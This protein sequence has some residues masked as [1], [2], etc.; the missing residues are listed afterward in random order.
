MK[1]Y[2]QAAKAIQEKQPDFKPKFAIITGSGLGD[3]VNHI[4]EAFSIPYQDIPHFPTPSVSGH[5]GQLVLGF[6]HGVPVACL[7][8]RVHY[9]EGH[10]NQVMT[11]MLRT[12]K[13][14]G[15]DSLLV[16][17][18]SGSMNENVT[19]GNLVLIYD[20]INMQGRNPLVGPNDDEMGPRFVAMDNAYDEEYRRV[21]QKAAKEVGVSL[22]SGVYVSVLGPT[23]ETAAEIRAFKALGGDLVGMSTA[24]DVIVARH[25]GLRVVAVAVITNMAT[26]MQ[27]HSLSHTETLENASRA[28]E[29]LIK[30]AKQFFK[31]MN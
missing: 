3:I 18:S 26:G 11:V 7:Q 20:Q 23:F 17:N 14:L 4:E 24:P 27:A 8:G 29:N 22:A 9:Y 28:S 6:L 12:M 16:T 2:Q 19:P 13:V 25:A 30:L 31:E 15:C 1:P 10:D 5:G 21:M